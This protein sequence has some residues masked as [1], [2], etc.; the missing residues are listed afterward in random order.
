MAKVAKDMLSHRVIRGSGLMY[1]GYSIVIEREDGRGR[2]QFGKD[3]FRV[4]K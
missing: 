2:G 1:G 3:E 4:G